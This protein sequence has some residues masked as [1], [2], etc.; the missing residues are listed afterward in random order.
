M[1]RAVAFDGWTLGRVLTTGELPAK[2]PSDFDGQVPALF[3]TRVEVG[4]VVYFLGP[5][6]ESEP[7]LLVVDITVNSGFFG[8]LAEGR[9][10]EAFLRLCR[11]AHVSMFPGREAIPAKWG[12][13]RAGSRVSF[14]AE[15]DKRR[16]PARI[17]LD[18]HAKGTRHVY[19]Y[20]LGRKP[21]VLAEVR[22]DYAALDAAVEGL[23]EARLHAMDAL[24]LEPEAQVGARH[25]LTTLGNDEKLGLG[26]ST[27]QWLERLTSE[28]RA[29]VQKRLDRSI[30]LIG[31]AG[32]GKTLSLLVK[33]LVE[34]ERNFERQS[35]YRVLFLTFSQSNVNHILSAIASMDH[36]G[37]LNRSE[38]ATLKVC[39]VQTLAYEALRLDQYGLEPV[40]LDGI[41]G[42]NWQRW[43]LE[44]VLERY[45]K[46]DWL[47][48]K[49]R[50]SD[51]VRTGVEAEKGAPAAAT[52]IGALMNEFAC[53]VEPQGVRRGA[54]ERDAYIKARRKQW[55]V[56]LPNRE[57]RLCVLD[58]YDRFRARLR[59]D[60]CIGA[61][62]MTADYLLELGTN[63][64]DQIRGRD[65]FDV[66]FVDELHLF[67]RQERMIPH[68]LMRDTNRPPVVVMAYDFKQS[69]RVTFGVPWDQ[70]GPV[71]LS[72]DMGLGETERFELNTAFRY[73]PEIAALLEWIDQA[74]PAVGMAEELGNEWRRVSSRSSRESG[75][76]PTLVPLDSTEETYSFVF[77]RAQQRARFLKRGSTV[78]VLCLSEQLFDTY[79]SA[80]AFRDYFLAIT[81]RE[82]LSGAYKAGL[83]FVLSMPEFVAGMQFDTVYLIE[84]NDGEVGEGAD[85]QGRS[86]QFVSQVYLGASRA[87]RV[88]E[89]Y[90]SKNRGGASRCFLHAM[91]EGALQLA[92]RDD[93][94]DV[95]Q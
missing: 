13:Y 8:E 58:L 7:L 76:R 9:R 32:T 81:D 88:L 54:T 85:Y 3:A 36:E 18:T 11:A 77:P 43:I 50:C 39:T 75:Q 6:R 66:V 46:G 21:R 24:G 30:R 10:A 64:W 60:A 27:K 14:F 94:P 23:D 17:E 16:E 53:V 69:T 83:R 62:Q 44:E 20:C 72:R 79:V 57:D 2:W 47:T 56:D 68:L 89:I 49:A 31:A 73:T 74:M 95:T 71:H 80:G 93:L 28:Q 33:C 87:E 78:A 5:N 67:N 42:R 40:S 65:G 15:H 45:R 41:E 22:I 4:E 37:V 12:V 70:V 34:F 61:D 86:L 84:A 91:Q 52:F 25:S 55:M 26:L 63:R 82:Q 29:F 92:D 38:R 48:R 90:S 35:G 59:E 51:W 19:A 1:T